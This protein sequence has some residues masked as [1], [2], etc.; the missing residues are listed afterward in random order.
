MCLAC[1]CVDDGHHQAVRA[2]A[3]ADDEIVFG[4]I[5]GFVGDGIAPTAGPDALSFGDA[6]SDA[7][8]VVVLFVGGV[9]G[10]ARL[11]KASSDRDTAGRITSCMRVILAEGGVG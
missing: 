9:V 1:F 4:E 10:K 2:A 3:P 6:V 7:G 5:R 8:A 11:G